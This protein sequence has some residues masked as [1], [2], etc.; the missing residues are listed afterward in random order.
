MYIHQP[1]LDEWREL[2]CAEPKRWFVSTAAAPAEKRNM[3][4]G[5]HPHTCARKMNGIEFSI[6]KASLCTV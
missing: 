2:L 5:D 3:L 1:L 4:V 6:E